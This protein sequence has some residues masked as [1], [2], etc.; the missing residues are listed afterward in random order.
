[1]TFIC[2]LINLICREIKTCFCWRVPQLAVLCYPASAGCRGAGPAWASWAPLSDVSSGGAGAGPGLPEL[3]DSGGWSYEWAWAAWAVRLA[4]SGI[5]G[6]SLTP[7]QALED[8]WRGW[9]DAGHMGLMSPDSGDSGMWVLGVSSEHQWRDQPRPEPACASYLL[10]A[11]ELWSRHSESANA[12][13][14]IIWSD[15]WQGRVTELRSELW[16]WTA[17]SLF[18]LSRSS[19]WQ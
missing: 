7:A 12:E 14:R 15:E 13:M 10:S 11:G 19:H 4:S 16:A 6:P 2:H 3:V 9:C 18:I 5:S 1:M 8:Q 17:G